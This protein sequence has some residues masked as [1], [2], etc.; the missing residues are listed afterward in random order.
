[1]SQVTAACGPG[2]SVLSGDDNL[3]LPLLAIG[4][5]GVVSVIANI[6]PRETAEMVHAALEGDWKRAR[7]LL[8]P[9]LP[10]ARPALL[11]ETPPAQRGAIDGRHTLDPD[12]AAPVSQKRGAPRER[13]RDPL[14]QR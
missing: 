9:L 11:D 14:A 5:Q 1:M 7:H 12:P 6:L 3:T 8:P 4:G 13:A 2:F 10:L